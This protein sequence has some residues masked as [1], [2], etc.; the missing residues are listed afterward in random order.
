MTMTPAGCIIAG[1]LARRMGGGDKGE[2]LVGGQTV[3]AR[4]IGRLR[5]QVSSLAINSNGDPARLAKLGLP[6]ISDPLPGQLGPLAGLL[7]A[8]EWSDAPWVVT[9]PSDT[10]FIPADL[11]MRLSEAAQGRDCA[12]AQSDGRKHPVCGIWRT[13]L[14]P[15]LRREI[16][17]GMRKVEAWAARLDCGVADWAVQPYDPFF[18]INRPEDI[19][20][21]QHIGAEFHP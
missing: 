5:P 7:A 13:S 20:T 3:M 1:G 12:I 8:L 18:N 17:H 21:A 14:G 16:E 4:I 10:P 2:T 11:V 15:V 9:V 19:A 6:I